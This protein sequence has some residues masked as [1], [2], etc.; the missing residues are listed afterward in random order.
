MK[1]IFTILAFIAVTVSSFCQN[2]DEITNNLE[3][4]SDSLFNTQQVESV[5]VDSFAVVGGMVY[6]AGKITAYNATGKKIGTA[7][8]SFNVNS[9]KTGVYFITAQEGT[10]KFV[11]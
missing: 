1:R 9:L 6:S 8:Q 11:K 5:S 7:L 2:T 4:S 10:I 3:T